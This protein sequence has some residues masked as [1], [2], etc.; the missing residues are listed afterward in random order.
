MQTRYHSRFLAGLLV[1]VFFLASC[2]EN[3]QEKAYVPEDSKVIKVETVELKQEQVS[4]PVA[5]TGILHSEQESKL[6][7][8]I[9]GIIDKIFVDEGQQFRAGQ[10]LARLELQEINAQV[11]KALENVEKLE[12]DMKRVES[13][14][15]DTVAT[16]EQVQDIQ[17]AV[18]VANADLKIAR[19][20]QR[21][22]SIVARYSGK[23]LKR[24]AE[25][26][27]LAGPGTPILIVG[28]ADRKNLLLKLMV[29]DKDI[30]RVK[31]GDSARVMFDPY[32]GMRFPATV[33]ETGQQADPMTGLF[34]VEISLKPSNVPLKNGF[35]GKAEVFPAMESGLVKIPMAAIV[36]A[37]QDSALVY[38]AVPASGT[39]RSRWVSPAYIEEAYVWVPFEQ[40]LLDFP[41]ITSGSFYVREGIQI[42]IQNKKP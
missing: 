1:L 38:Q 5:G 20:N 21:Y 14:Y 2:R 40:G 30:I 18:E 4:L 26:G 7:F 25:P 15:Q 32:P 11:S 19:Y 36:E 10:V 33:T 27:E 28:N 9:G 41:L 42:D 31:P 3:H 6:S 34:E 12:R 23:V 37:D 39:A 8:K 16:L 29:S 24:F 17:T 35:I 13:L 22:A